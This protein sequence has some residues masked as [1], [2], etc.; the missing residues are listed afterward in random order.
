M[1]K[2][3]SWRFAKTSHIF[4]LTIT[5]TVVV[6]VVLASLFAVIFR[7]ARHNAT[8]EERIA[9]EEAIRPFLAGHQSLDLKE[10]REIH[11]E[12]TMTLFAPDGSI[13]ERVGPF[14][15][16][17]TEGFRQEGPVTSFGIRYGRNFLVVGASWED[18]ERG[19][20][21]LGDVLAIL[22]LPLVGLVA[23]AT[24]RSAL[25]VFEPL[26]RLAS[27]ASEISGKQLDQRLAI[28]DEAE[29]GILASQLNA[30][31]DRLE[32]SARREEQFSG[33][34]AHELRTP[35]AILRTQ[36]ETV[37]LKDRSTSDYRDA[38]AALLREVD[39]LTATTESLL[40]TARASSTPAPIVDIGPLVEQAVDR[41][42]VRFA[43]S[44]RTLN[45]Q[46]EP[47]FVAMLPAE[48]T[49]LLDN[50][51]Q[52]AHRYTPPR[53]KTEVTLTS[54]GNTVEL[55]VRDDGPGIAEDLAETIFSRF[56]RG[57]SSR[58]STTGGIGIG[59]SLC[60]KIVESRQGSIS[61][62]PVPVGAL[63]V[64][65]WPADS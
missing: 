45:C 35:L 61:V 60:K 6:G 5:T 46:T 36:I 40:A 18:S 34:A 48:L 54:K 33:D 7:V 26:N 64:C 42:R 2:V 39:R 32:S 31:L 8:A 62:R 15:L 56:V 24:W 50:L 16:R 41:W 49:I 19:L 4:R 59:L 57:E 28:Q 37:L 63:F 23:F 51:L 53:G 29:F 21:Q 38:L 22:W 47:A 9:L 58:N 20:R 52:N 25:S 12:M 14:N 30:M 3:M 13:L 44:G 11:P 10:F 17:L 55:S 43:E 1:A 65:R 27:Q